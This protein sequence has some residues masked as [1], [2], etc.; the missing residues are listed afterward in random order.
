MIDEDGVARLGDFGIIG[1][2]DP[3][4]GEPD[5]AVTFKP[6]IVRYM[7]PELLKSRLWCLSHDSTPTKECDIYSLAMTTYEVFSSHIVHGITEIAICCKIISG[8]LPYGSAN[9]NDIIHEILTGRR[10][11]LPTDAQRL[12]KQV[13]IM[14]ERCWCGERELRW[15]I[16][17]V[18]KQLLVSSIK[19]IVQGEGGKKF[20]LRE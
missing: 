4:V 14:V 6:G 12:P 11:P 1:V 2:I 19:G 9:D 7:A 17:A 10:P 16:R 5:G 8:I 18:C 13:W 20:P 3:S 15:D